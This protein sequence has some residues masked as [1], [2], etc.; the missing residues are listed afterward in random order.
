MSRLCR[1]YHRYM[2]IIN[3]NTLRR[4]NYFT[5]F[6]IS[7]SVVTFSVFFLEITS[8]GSQSCIVYLTN[9]YTGVDLQKCQSQ[10]FYTSLVIYFFQQWKYNESCDCKIYF[11]L[12][13]VANSMEHTIYNLQLETVK[14]FYLHYVQVCEFKHSLLTGWNICASCM[15]YNQKQIQAIDTMFLLISESTLSNARNCQERII[16]PFREFEPVVFRDLCKYLLGIEV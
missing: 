5:L 12:Q 15:Q 9:I 10:H 4:N 7:T 16:K 3:H 8:V 13:V 1:Q 2:E 14:Q 6:H 11:E